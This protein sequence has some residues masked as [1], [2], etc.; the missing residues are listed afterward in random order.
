MTPT[1]L[2][3]ARVAGMGWTA[4]VWGH[5]GLGWRIR[6]GLVLL[7]TALVA[8]VVGPELVPTTAPPSPALAWQAASEIVTGA[9]LGLSAALILAAARQAGELVAAQAGFSAAAF[10]DPEA[11]GETTPMG[12]LY[13]LLALGVFLALD[14]PLRLVGALLESYR[15]W[16]VGS[17]ALNEAS[18]TEVFDRVGWSLSLALRA[19]APVAVAMIG[20]GVALSWISRA[21]GGLSFTS[22][23]M[24]LRCAMGLVLVLLGLATVAALMTESWGRLLP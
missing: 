14:G 5:P 13:G 20:V 8:P 24:P 21:A 16:P 12:H 18:V 1:L 3:L 2:V 4:P 23:T 19:A 7:I 22:L 17:F 10:F 15:A 9:V 11:G 6:I